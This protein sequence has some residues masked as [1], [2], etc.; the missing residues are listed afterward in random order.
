MF[1]TLKLAAAMVALAVSAGVGAQDNFPSRPIRW[2]VPYAPGTSPDNTVRIVAEAMSEMLKQTIVIENKTGA[3]GNLGA[4]AVA[5]AAP[6]G[7]T[8]V[9]SATPM[10]MSMRT[11]KKPGYDVMKDFVHVGRIGTSDLTVVTNPESGIKSMRDLIE[12]ARKKPGGLMYASGGIGSP[13]H[14]GAELMLAAV[15]VEAT[16]VPF[17]GANESVNAVIGKQVDFALAITSVALPQVDNGKLLPLAVTSAQ[18]HAR[19]PSVP[20]LKEAGVPVTLVSIGGLSVPV[21]TPQTVVKHLADTLNKALARADVRSRIDA[22]GGRTAP[23]TPEEYAAALR[24]EIALTEKLMAAARL[25]A[26]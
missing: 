16:H 23:S 12:R 3:A 11:Y 2:I 4:Q 5:R 20:T 9:Y 24:D 8:W 10:A 18:R 25:E 6:D 7:Y 14:M 1:K 15:G 22:L 26:Q 19:L 21:G 13:A 17:K